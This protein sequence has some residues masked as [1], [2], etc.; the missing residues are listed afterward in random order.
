MNLILQMLPPI[1]LAALAIYATMLF[2]LTARGEG[3]PSQGADG[4]EQAGSTTGAE[5]KYT[6]GIEAG[7][8]P[9]GEATWAL[10]VTISSP[11]DPLER[12]AD[13]WR[14]LDPAGTV[15][16]EQELAHDHASEQPSTHSQ[17]GLEIPR[18]VEEIT[19]GGRDLKNGYGSDM[20]TILV[21]RG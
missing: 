13:G 15:L 21:K 8:E 4:E 19:A 12:Y 11:H 3:Q 6:D 20:V 14:V 1:R 16:G 5:Q 2:L 18:D 10:S 17:F 7:L 9:S